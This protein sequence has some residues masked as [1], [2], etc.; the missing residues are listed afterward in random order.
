MTICR[1]QKMKTIK[2]LADE[3]GISKQALNK[4]IDNLGC[5]NQLSK[6]GNLWLIPESVENTIKSKFIDNQKT[7]TKSTTVDSSVDTLVA[8][9]LKQLE[10]K[11]KQIETLLKTVD[12][13]QQLQALAEQK[14]KLLEQKNETPEEPQKPRWKFWK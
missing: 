10:E 2:Q 7:T 4:R 6:N 12:Q 3:L 11:D 14:I 5:R 1:G 13:A 9:L 8:T